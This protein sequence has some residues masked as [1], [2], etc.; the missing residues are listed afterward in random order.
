MRPS[1]SRT[2]ISWVPQ[3]I[4]LPQAPQPFQSQKGAPY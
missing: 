3:Q 2:V 1:G 4:N